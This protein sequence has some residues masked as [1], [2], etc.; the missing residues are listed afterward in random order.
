MDVIRLHDLDSLSVLFEEATR[1]NVL[2]NVI[3]SNKNQRKAGNSLNV[4]QWTISRWKTG[5]TLIPVGMLLK[6]L[7]FTG[8]N[9]EDVEKNVVG[10]GSRQG[11]S[12]INLKLPLSLNEDLA[13]ILGL[14]ITDGHIDKNLNWLQFTNKSTVLKELFMEKIK[15]IFNYDTFYQPSKDQMQLYVKNKAIATIFWKIGIPKGKKTGI[16]S[17]PKAISESPKNV[18]SSFLRGCFDGDGSA[19]HSLKQ[20]LRIINFAS[21]SRQMLD[22]VHNALLNFQIENHVSINKHGN[23]YVNI[24]NRNNLQNFYNSISFGHPEKRIKLEN[25]LK[26]YKQ[27]LST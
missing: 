15:A 2:R 26:S 13:Y 1:N 6:L 19:C 23:G 18:L 11:S 12:V 25:M 10:I 4:G 22:D 21:I 27:P 8:T 17:I 24:T 9:V 20:G 16:T 7:K 14:I 5:K 3:E